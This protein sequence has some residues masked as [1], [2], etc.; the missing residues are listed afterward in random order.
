MRMWITIVAVVALA[1]G[2]KKTDAASNAYVNEKMP[3]AMARMQDGEQILKAT[4]G[5]LANQPAAPPELLHA[6]KTLHTASTL[7][8]NITPPTAFKTAHESYR[9]LCEQLAGNIDGMVAAAN[10]HDDPRFTN[11]YSAGLTTL[12]TLISTDTLWEQLVREAHVTQNKL[13]APPAD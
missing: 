5:A 9:E 11:S 12:Q 2:C 6:A 3:V 10:A 4:S 1:T 7:M 13:P 8:A